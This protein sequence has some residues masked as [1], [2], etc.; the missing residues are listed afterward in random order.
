MLDCLQ[1]ALHRFGGKADAHFLTGFSKAFQLMRTRA[2][3]DYPMTVYYGFKQSETDKVD[4]G[5]ASTGWETML[6]GLLKAGFQITGTLPMRTETQRAHCCY[7]HKCPRFFNCPCL[8]P[9]AQ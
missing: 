1:Q 5:I 4:G 7:W 2:H 8:S 6:E 9:A 3:P